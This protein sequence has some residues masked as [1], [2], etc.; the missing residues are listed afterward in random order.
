MRKNA[1]HKKLH[2]WIL[3]MQCFILKF[4]VALG[5]SNFITNTIDTAVIRSSRLL[6]FCKKGVLTNFAKF[7]KKHLRQNLV[8][9]QAADLQSL[10]LSRKGDSAT[11][12]FVN[13]AE[14]LIRI[15]LIIIGSS[16][17]VVFYKKCVLTNFPKFTTKHL[18]QSLV[19]NEAADCR[20]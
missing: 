3:F 20:V 8:L 10:T 17:L 1:D 14:F 11:Y 7:T 18:C 16:H 9:K 19:F 13:S 2:I 4:T 15:F 6:V 5:N 12:L